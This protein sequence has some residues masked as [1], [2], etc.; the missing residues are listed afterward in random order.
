MS[1]E[2]MHWR[3]LISGKPWLSSMRRPS[4]YIPRS[5]GWMNAQEP[6]WFLFRSRSELEPFIALPAVI[7]ISHRRSISLIGCARTNR[8]FSRRTA[9]FADVQCYLAHRLAGGPFRTGWLSADSFGIYD[10]VERQWSSQ[11]LDA[12]DLSTDRLPVT[13]PPG[14]LLGTVSRQAASETGVPE[15]LPI[16]AAGGDGAYAGL[17]TDCTRTDRAYVN[18]GTAVS[19]ERGRRNT[20]MIARGGHFWPPR[21]RDMSSKV[22]CAQE[23]S[24]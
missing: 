3:S 15:G 18:L 22:C 23:H 12:I 8:K 14:Q 9:C 24:L 21:E 4:R 5:S 13:I 11:L 16:F 20:A 1:L 2:L 6:T 19:R 7:P 17:G 10:I